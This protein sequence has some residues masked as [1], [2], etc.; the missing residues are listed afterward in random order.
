MGSNLFFSL[1][2][3]NLNETQMEKVQCYYTNSGIR[4]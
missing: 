2:F 1:R 4:D 3:E